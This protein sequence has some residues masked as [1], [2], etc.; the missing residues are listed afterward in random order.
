MDTAA[1]VEQLG[2]KNQEVLNRLAPAETLVSESG[3]GS[4]PRKPAKN[5]P[6]Q[7]NGS[8]R[9]RGPVAHFHR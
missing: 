6:A 9:D 5:R 1:F 2:A 4:T 8:D 7:R 3:G